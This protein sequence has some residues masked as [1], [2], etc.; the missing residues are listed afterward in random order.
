VKRRAGNPAGSTIDGPKGGP[1]FTSFVLRIEFSNPTRI[2]M[3]K[4]LLFLITLAS[5]AFGV[6]SPVSAQMG[7]P[8][9]PA[10]LRKIKASI[11]QHFAER[12]PDRV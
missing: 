5:I 4:H 12:F 6:C 10:E 2:A 11:A 3:R 7:P 9:I 8:R 1:A